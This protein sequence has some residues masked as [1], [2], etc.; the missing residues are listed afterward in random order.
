M[1]SGGLAEWTDGETAYLSV[2]FSWRL[3]AARERALWYHCRGYRVRAGGPAVILNPDVLADVAEIGG[4]VDAL[5]HHNPLATFTTRGCPNRC[6]FC[7]VP[8]IEGTFRELADWP[9]RPVI[10]DNNLL[11]SSET[12]FN[13]VIDR[14]L[15]ARVRGVDFNQGL[16]IRL[17]TEHHAAR[18]AELYRSGQM[19][20][21]RLAWDDVRLESHFLRA[22]RRLV[23]AGIPARAI[24]VYCLIGFNDTPDDARYRLE[25][26]Y[27][28]LG[29]VP[30]PMRYQP[31][32]AMRRNEYVANGWTKEELTRFTRYWSRL[33]FWERV[34]VSFDEYQRG[35]RRI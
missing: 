8:I 27:H 17:L 31:L 4:E 14:L 18:L 32:N 1:W 29:S 10:C 2:A 22:H 21:V 9:V 5:P 26:I 20:F 7:A 19:P 24:R 15:E 16:D 12:H 35:Y 25:K 11:A 33:F 34:G 28:T 13:R 3:R 23:E 30:Y 6:P